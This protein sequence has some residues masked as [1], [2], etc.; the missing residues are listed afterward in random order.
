MRPRPAAA[1]RAS[2]KPTIPTTQ[3]S[4]LDQLTTR[5]REVLAVLG[6]GLSNVE[7][8]ARLG[9]SE[10]TAKTLVSRVLAKLG[11]ASRV[12]AAIIRQGDRAGLS[13][14]PRRAV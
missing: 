1:Y 10:A 2:R 9:I 5:A 4:A 7:I 14:T 13:V 8:A 3:A 6:Q 12:Q 11:C